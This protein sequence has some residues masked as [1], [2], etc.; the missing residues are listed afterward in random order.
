MP[1][2][3]RF[4]L[5]FTHPN[6]SAS[7]RLQAGHDAI[8]VVLQRAAISVRLETIAKAIIAAINAYSMDVAPSSSAAKAE[9]RERFMLHISNCRQPYAG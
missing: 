4:R 8:E 5:S 2:E 3:V 9:S 6:R 1:N 7:C